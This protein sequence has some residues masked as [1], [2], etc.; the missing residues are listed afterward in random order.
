MR[1]LAEAAAK[2]FFPD[3][4][5]VAR[6]DLERWKPLQILTPDPLVTNLWC[7]VTTLRRQKDNRDQQ[8]ENLKITSLRVSYYSIV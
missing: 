8:I 6:V 2:S 4:S 1:S 3:F 5:S 7:Y